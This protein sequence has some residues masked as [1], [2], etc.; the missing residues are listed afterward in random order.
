METPQIQRR[1]PVSD[2]LRLLFGTAAQ[3]I[4]RTPAPDHYKLPAL[5]ASVRI[6][7]A[8]WKRLEARRETLKA[9]FKRRGLDPE[10]RTLGISWEARKKRETAWE[11]QQAKRKIALKEL[12]LKV[13]MDLLGMS[14]KQAKVYLQQLQ[15]TL[16]KI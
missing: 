10:G 5:S 6:I 8:E 13:G 3:R 14:T 12:R 16:A 11:A 1:P 15:K 7:H 2:L 9:Q 4:V